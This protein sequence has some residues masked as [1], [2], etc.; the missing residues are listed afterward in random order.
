MNASSSSLAATVENAVV[1]TVVLAVDPSLDVVASIA[2][3]A[4]AELADRHTSRAT[5]NS[6]A[7]ERHM[8]NLDFYDGEKGY[9]L[10][11]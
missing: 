7:A 9:T 8:Q 2:I 4:A 5:V 11:S 1:A 3:D 10:A 6:P